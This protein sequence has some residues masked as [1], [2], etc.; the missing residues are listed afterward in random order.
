MDLLGDHGFGLND[1][2][3][4]LGFSQIQNVLHHFFIALRKKNLAPVFLHIRRELVQIRVQMGY[5]MGADGL[6]T[7][8]PFLNVA[9]HLGGIGL[10]HAEAFLGYGQGAFEKGV[11]NGNLHPFIK[12]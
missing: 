12:R 7:L 9:K 4:V 2:F 10:V 5:R 8:P 1:G 11:L 3:G 6:R